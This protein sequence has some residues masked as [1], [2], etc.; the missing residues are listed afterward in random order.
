[1]SL[2]QIFQ[3]MKALGHK[4]TS[5]EP[6]KSLGVLLYTDEKIKRAGRGLFKLG[7]RAAPKAKKK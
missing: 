7:G 2:D 4:S 1:M 5:N 6:K 3:T